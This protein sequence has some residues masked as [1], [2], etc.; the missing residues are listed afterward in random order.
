MRHSIAIGIKLI[1]VSIVILSLFGIFN[2]AA[3]MPL[4]LM[5]LIATGIGY[6]IGDLLILRR[7]G[8]VSASLADF[9]LHF[10]TI[11]ALASM[12]LG[13]S[14]PLMIASIAA[15]YLITVTE[16]LYHAY[17]IERVFVE[18]DE[19]DLDVAMPLEYQTEFA[20]EEDPEVLKTKN[21]SE[22]KQTDMNRHK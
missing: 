7:F 6:L 12:F 2:Q 9:V 17:L 5:S 10:L 15:S 20:E 4:I 22:N 1:I 19:K 16:P 11:W 13:T 3:L 18:D 8:N 14:T 21:I